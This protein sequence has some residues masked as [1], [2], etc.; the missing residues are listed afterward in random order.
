MNTVYVIV[1][2][3][4][5]SV[6]VFAQDT[7]IYKGSIGVEI[8]QAH[9][10]KEFAYNDIY[11]DESGC[12]LNGLHFNLSYTYMLTKNFGVKTMFIANNNLT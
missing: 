2:L 11:N 8:G 10:V 4:L 3:V 12:A 9:P 1:L 6:S 7:T 5:V